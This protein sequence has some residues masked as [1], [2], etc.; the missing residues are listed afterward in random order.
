MAGC[1][2]QVG[3]LAGMPVVAGHQVGRWQC[4]AGGKQGAGLQELAAG[5][6]VGHGVSIE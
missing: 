2:Q 5:K 3:K 1:R 4:D 6:A